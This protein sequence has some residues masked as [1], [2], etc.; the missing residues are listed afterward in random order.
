MD[1]TAA[2][3][4][5]GTDKQKQ[6]STEMSAAA[7]TLKGMPGA[8]ESAIIRGMSQIR[9]YIDGQQMSNAI[10]PHMSAGMAGRVLMAAK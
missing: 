9:I 3:L 7:G 1:K 6:S 5:G 4:S 10:E 2:E 8:V